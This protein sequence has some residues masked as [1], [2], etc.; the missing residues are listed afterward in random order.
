MKK[1]LVL[2]TNYF[3]FYKGEEYLE[4]EITVLSNKFEKIYLIP[5]MINKGEKQTR[6]VPDNVTILVPGVNHGKFNR[7][8]MFLLGLKIKPVEYKKIN[9]IKKLYSKYFES[10]ANLIYKNIEKELFSEDFSQFEEIKIYSYWLYITAR[11]GVSLKKN[12]FINN[13][14]L[15]IT[16]AHRYDLYEDNTK[17]KFLPEREFL[18]QNIDKIYP[19]SDDGT[20]ELINKYPVYSEKIST[21][22]LGSLNQ[23]FI[24]GLS[25]QKLHIVSCSAIRKVKRIDLIIEALNILESNN[26]DY[27][28]THIGD[29]PEMKMIVKL[30][31]IKLQKKNFE[32]K[33]FLSNT[34][35]FK[36]YKTND[37][38]VFINVSA[39]EGIPVSIMEAMSVG[40]PVIATDV[41]GTKEIVNSANGYLLPSNVTISQI[42]ECLTTFSKYNEQEIKILKENAYYTWE[43]NYNSQENYKEFTNEIFDLKSRR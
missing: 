24:S 4:S 1:C 12:F 41:G 34:D 31:N 27:F 29:G 8:R 43:N 39:S 42:N 7:V 3:P 15:L 40:I 26:I 37:I 23:N 11:V 38:S 21:R 10:R 25:N 18:L 36:F 16:R 32:F 33:G 19:V 2:L 6:K 35:V 5:T 13:N 17:L 28:W 22:R 14:V 20:K 9:L 30:A